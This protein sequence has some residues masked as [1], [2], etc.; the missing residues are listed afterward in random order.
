VHE[1][2][3]GMTTADMVHRQLQSS[4]AGLTRVSIELRKKHF[5]RMMGC[6][7]KPGNDELASSSR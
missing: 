4:Y 3:D 6:R 1:A 7:V 5:V 2:A